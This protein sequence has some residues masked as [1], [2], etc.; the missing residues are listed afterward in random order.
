MLAAVWSLAWHYDEYI[1]SLCILTNRCETGPAWRSAVHL[2]L[3]EKNGAKICIRH[4]V[5][6]SLC[7]QVLCIAEV[8]SV[9]VLFF[10]SGTNVSQMYFVLT[11]WFD[12]HC[13]QVFEH[14]SHAENKIQLSCFRKQMETECHLSLIYIFLK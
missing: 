4:E 7:V 13:L 3:W 11:H 6:V 14:V 10:K 9:L 5:L 12:F 2:Q 8:Y 1:S